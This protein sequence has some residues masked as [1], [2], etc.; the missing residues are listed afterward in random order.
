MKSKIGIIEMKRTFGLLLA[1]ACLCGGLQETTAQETFERL[2]IRIE[3]FRDGHRSGGWIA[4]TIPVVR[5][6]EEFDINQFE[7]IY[8]DSEEIKDRKSNV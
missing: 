7:S 2:E 4:S 5:D 1:V 6:I 3:Y 8:G